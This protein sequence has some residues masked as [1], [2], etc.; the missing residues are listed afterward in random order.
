MESIRDALQVR[1]FSNARSITVILMMLS[2]SNA[3]LIFWLSFMNSHALM[4]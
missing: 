3:G 2:F 1:M 4:T